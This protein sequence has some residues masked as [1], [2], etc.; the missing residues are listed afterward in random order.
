MKQ[1]GLAMHNCHQAQNC[2]PQAAGFFPEKCGRPM[3]YSSGPDGIQAWP[4]DP[5]PGQSPIS[6]SPD[7]PPANIGT[8]H[9]MLL[10]YMEQEAIYMAYMGCTQ[11]YDA[12]HPD[13]NPPLAAARQVWAFLEPRTHLSLPP[14]CYICPS[15]TSME[16]NGMILEAGTPG[17][18]G[19]SYVA[20]IQALGCFY[21]TQPSY[22]THPTVESW[23]DGSSN[24]IVFVERL[25]G[26]PDYGDGRAAWVGVV[27][28]PEFNPFYGATDPSNKLDP[29][30]YYDVPPQ[31]CPAVADASSAR[32]QSGH[33]GGINALL[34][35]GSV[36][37]ISPY[38]SKQTWVNA[39]LP[40]DGQVLGNDW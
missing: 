23:T 13:Y 31:D 28:V 4:D 14:P 5:Y 25:A 10:P 2:F 24:T 9:Y 26:A 7:H 33:P 11:N 8:I 21:M 15:D 38:I 36:R 37:N 1:I 19:T 17:L 20:N 27:P 32:C 30:H 34:G 16:P 6:T 29:A 40:N 22:Q 18:G 35:D 12:G 39:I 3:P